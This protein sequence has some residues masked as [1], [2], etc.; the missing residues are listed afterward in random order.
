MH[1]FYAWNVTQNHDPIISQLVSELY[2]TRT[3]FTNGSVFYETRDRQTDRDG[4]EMHNAASHTEGH[5]ILVYSSVRDGFSVQFYAHIGD[6][7]FIRQLICQLQTAFWRHQNHNDV[8]RWWRKCTGAWQLGM[9]AIYILDKKICIRFVV[10]SLLTSFSS[11]VITT[12]TMMMMMMMMMHGWIMSIDIVG[13]Q[14]HDAIWHRKMQH[15][16]TIN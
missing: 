5:I 8:T 13:M 2:K 10:D 4:G 11:I 14:I 12:T 9:V 1:H 16:L 15:M 3:T 7:L 6:C